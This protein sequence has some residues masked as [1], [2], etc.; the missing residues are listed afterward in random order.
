MIAGPA[1]QAPRT[2]THALLMIPS[3]ALEAAL[4]KG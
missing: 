2:P 1:G 3:A 4:P